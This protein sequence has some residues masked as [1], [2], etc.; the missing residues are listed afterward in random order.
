VHPLPSIKA[1]LQ[2]KTSGRLFQI[3]TPDVERPSGV[4]ASE[5]KDFQDRVHISEDGLFFDYEVR[6]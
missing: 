4:S 1:A 2:K 5:W 6:N 3:D